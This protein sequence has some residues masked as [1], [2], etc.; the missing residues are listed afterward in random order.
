MKT[1]AFIILMLALVS[2]QPKQQKATDSEWI[3]LF[4]G[5]DLT[6]WDL[7]LSGYE[8]N[9]N[10]NNTFRVENGLLK[11]RYDEYEM[12]NGEFGHLFFNQ[13]FSHYKLRVEYRFV[14][15]QV[16]GGPEWA[17]KNN[18]VMFHSQSAES[19][20]LDQDFPV[21]VE[22]QFLGGSGEGE[23]PT[24]NVCTPGT[25]VVMEGKL[26]TQHCT[27]SRSKTYPGEEWITFE[28]VVM[29]DEIIHHIVNGDTVMTYSHPQIGGG[30][31]PE[32][33]PVPD[34]TPLREGYIAV[35][36]ESHPTDFRKIELLDLSK[37]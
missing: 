1:N 6:G 35:Q 28:L 29:G 3:Q 10:F 21:S 17:Y 26:I 36:A 37:K 32:D 8:L 24:G 2:C 16:V 30:N 34:G 11:I 15:E 27:S 13:K 31:K 12:F 25:N 23:R 18:G 33:Y 14:G 7:K 20:G 19:M 5:T 4:N 9:D 22:A